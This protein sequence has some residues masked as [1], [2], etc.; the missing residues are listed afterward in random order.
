EL[1]P[2]ASAYYFMANTISY[3]LFLVTSNVSSA[4][5][6]EG[7]RSPDRVVALT[8]AALRNSALLVLPAAG[9]GALLA[10]PVLSLFGS[11]YADH[12]AV[13]LQLLLLSAVP[14]VVIAVALAAA[15]LRQDLRTIALTYGVAAAI[16]YGGSWVGVKFIGLNGVGV[17]CLVSQITVAVLLLLSGRS[18]LWPDRPGWRGPLSELER[19]PAGLRRAW[20]RRETRRRLDPALK[21][22]GL[23]PTSEYRLLTSDSDVLVVALDRAPETL[24]VK[25]AT[26]HA[27]STGLVRHADLLGWLGSE[28]DGSPTAALLPRPVALRRLQ[29]ERVLVETGLPGTTGTDLLAGGRGLETQ[30]TAAALTAITEIHRRTAS[31]TVVDPPMF[32]DWVDEPLD[33][34]RRLPAWAA[35][36]SALDRLTELL[37]ECLDGLEVTAAAV[38]GDFWSGNV[39]FRVN[40]A[41]PE[42]SGIVDW[43][44]GRRVGLPDTDLAHWWLAGQSVELGAAVRQALAAPQQVATELAALPVPLANPQLPLEATMLLTWLGHVS[45]G[46]SRATRNPVSP[47]WVARNI[48]P[49]VQLFAAPVTGRPAVK[50]A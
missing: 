22:C 20:T 19:I 17:A 24:V 38:H 42:V 41:A 36:P 26:S 39:L 3:G 45:A 1:G 44:N 50:A 18:G 32:R 30:L 15:R 49:V 9:L 23:A 46:L 4:L 27:A 34:L 14:Q 10:R 48:R 35:E 16:T 8:R 37:H 33:H 47:I 29:G 31:T 28:L 13:L 5:V 2:E 11:G 6:A 43:E 12:G 7:A 40:D 21:A 25:I